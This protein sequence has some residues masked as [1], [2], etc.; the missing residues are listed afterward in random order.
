MQ[1]VARDRHLRPDP[2]RELEE[3]LRTEEPTREKN[4]YRKMR[5]DDWLLMVSFQVK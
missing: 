5:V 4:V 1:Q 2:G 3:A